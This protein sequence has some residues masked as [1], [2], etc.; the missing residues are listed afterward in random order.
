MLNLEG[1]AY[2][3]IIA[4]YPGLGWLPLVYL[5]NEEVFRGEYQP[6]REEAV[7]KAF[8]WIDEELR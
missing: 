8:R 6:T 7:F 1:F 2:S 5:R 3:A 4:D